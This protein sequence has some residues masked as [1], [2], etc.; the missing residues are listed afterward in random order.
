MKNI[1]IQRDLTPI[2]NYLCDNGYNVQEFDGNAENATKIKDIDAIVITGLDNNVM[3]IHDTSTKV[4][5]INADGKTPED[6]RKTL[7]EENI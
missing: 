1:A 4:P 3:G 2:K 5:I 7:D 6:I